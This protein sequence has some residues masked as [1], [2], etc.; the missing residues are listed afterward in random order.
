MIIFLAIAPKLS[1]SSFSSDNHTWNL[2]PRPSSP[3]VIDDSPHPAA[4]QLNFVFAQIIIFAKI[5]AD[6]LRATYHRA[7]R[8]LDL[9]DDTRLIHGAA[10]G[11]GRRDHRHLE[12]TGKHIPLTNRGVGSLPLAPFFVVIDPEPLGGWQQTRILATEF[13]PRGL[14]ESEGISNLIDRIDSGRVSILIKISI[15]G[16]FNRLSQGLSSMSAPFCGD[17]AFHVSVSVGHA[18]AT[19][20]LS[21]R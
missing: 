13:N 11:Y 6:F 17:P 15:A 7:V 10:I 4:N 9:I 2:G 16:I 14:T 20:K 1:G 21:F 8:L 5:P 3:R 18:A 12:G 19:G